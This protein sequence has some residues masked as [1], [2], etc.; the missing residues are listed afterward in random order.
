MTPEERYEHLKPGISGGVIS[1]PREDKNIFSEAI[2]RTPL[3]VRAGLGAL[4]GGTAANTSVNELNPHA[5]LPTRIGADALGSIGGATLG[6]HA[7][8]LNQAASEYTWAM[9]DVAKMRSYLAERAKNLGKS[10]PFK[11][12]NME[13][14]RINAAENQAGGD[15]LKHLI[16][17][18]NPDEATNA[19]KS[20]LEFATYKKG[21]LS[22]IGSSIKNHPGRVY[23]AN[24]ATG[25]ALGT[26]NIPL[27]MKDP[28][29]GK[30]RQ[31]H[32]AN[33][34]SEFN[35]ATDLGG[36]G[37]EK[38]IRGALSP[39]SRLG[40]NALTTAVTFNRDRHNADKWTYGPLLPNK[41]KYGNNHAG[42]LSETALDF[43]PIQSATT[44]IDQLGL[45]GNYPDDVLNYLLGPIVGGYVR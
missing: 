40:M 21:L 35:E 42:A 15:T 5:N 12:P 26:G 10:E 39:T 13:A 20:L 24:R 29:T 25:G 45:N 6:T 11:S 8:A 14:Y 33:P 32:I 3:G 22:S 44:A 16:D 36:G 34:F 2:K 4:A 18:N 38:F 17:Y 30:N 31:L 19:L 41:D 7:P 28:K 27:P 1:S 37:T 9:D 43:L 23:A